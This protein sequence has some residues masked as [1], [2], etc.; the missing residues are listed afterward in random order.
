M[1][2]ALDLTTSL[3]ASSFRRWRGTLASAPVQQQ[4]ARPLELYEYE[5]SP[6][7]RLVREVLTELDLDALVR[8]C[9]QGGKRFRPLAVALGGK[10][11]FPFLVDPNTERALHE[12]ADIIDYLRATYAG[13]GPI[14]RG[15]RRQI[16]V[17][18]SYLASTVRGIGA[19]TPGQRARPSRAPNQPL[20]L[21]SF[22]ASPLA[23]PVR[24]LLSELELPYLLRN[25]AP[26]GWDAIRRS[27][28]PDGTVGGRNRER[29]QALTGGTQVPCLLDPNTGVVL[30]DAAEILDY[31]ESTY[32]VA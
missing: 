11:Q 4:P 23:R 30:Q 25:A 31:L 22:E 13:Q 2:D 29:M 1:L 27:L 26:A 16:G 3:V 17:G 6:Y 15:L 10:S 14:R 32:A 20:E 12:S 28:F 18:G 8:P 21:Y 7:C 5:A 9:P 19:G 24:E